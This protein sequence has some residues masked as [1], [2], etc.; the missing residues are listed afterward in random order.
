MNSEF[1]Q[2]EYD[3]ATKN[4]EDLGEDLKWII[5]RILQQ[6]K[7]GVGIPYHAIDFRVKS[8][9]SVCA[10]LASTVYKYPKMEDLDD[11]LGVRVITYFPDQVDEAAS[12]IRDAL[13]VDEAKSVDKRRMDYDRFGYLSL[14]YIATLNENYCRIATFRHYSGMRFELQIR[15]ILQHAW[16][17]IE[18]DLGYKSELGVPR[19]FRR[20][21]FRLAGLLEI[22]DIEFQSIRDGL[23]R[24]QE[25]AQAMIGSTPGELKIDQITLRTFVGGSTLLAHIN[26]CIAE[27]LDKAVDA[28]IYPNIINRQADYLTSIGLKTIKELE[29]HLM[30]A[31]SQTIDLAVDW[32]ESRAVFGQHRRKLPASL[33]LNYFGFIELLTIDD[34]DKAR[35]IFNRFARMS[36]GEFGNLKSLFESQEAARRERGSSST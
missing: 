32:L 29:R 31:E 33:A 18:H 28:A 5:Q 7:E 1:E 12:A 15:S 30:A 13:S 25:E 3:Q 36:A 14:H 20:R 6:A 4:M 23:H 21:F 11:L 2:T 26:Q 8:F 35:E 34:E 9:E 19:E 27:R 10:K 24:Y 22:A 16:A 17:E